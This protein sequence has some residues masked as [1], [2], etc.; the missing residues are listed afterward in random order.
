MRNGSP[1]NWQ[2]TG[3]EAKFWILNASS[4]FPLLLF[5]VNISWTTFF[6]V[7]ITMAAFFTLDY[8]GFK[9]RVFFRFLRSFAA[10]PRKL[11][12]PWW[13]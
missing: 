1:G 9:P 2:D 7:I 13:M 3:R 5:L 4:S 6:I 12:R 11:A 8:Y 10:G